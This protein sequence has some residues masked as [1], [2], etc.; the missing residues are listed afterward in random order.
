MYGGL[1]TYWKRVRYRLRV[2]LLTCDERR[3]TLTI[4]VLGLT[5]VAAASNEHTKHGPRYMSSRVESR[6]SL[7]VPLKKPRWVSVLQSPV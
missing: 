2:N 4:E 7:P 1:E 5:L 6:E 3:A